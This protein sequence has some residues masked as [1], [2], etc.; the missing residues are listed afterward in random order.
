MSTQ[1]AAICHSLLQGEVL[2]IMTAF[3]QFNC[4]NLPREI[5]RSVEQKF[6]V[7]ISRTKRNFV[8]TYGEP[9]FYYQYRLNRSAEYNQIGIEK[10]REYVTNNLG[11]KRDKKESIQQTQLF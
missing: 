9:G 5:S 3:K 6:G 10:M 8:S 7:Q 11:N 1:I 2:S 4:T